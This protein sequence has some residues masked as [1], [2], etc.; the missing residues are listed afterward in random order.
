M[1]KLRIRSLGGRKLIVLDF[2]ED[3]IKG[4]VQLEIRSAQAQNARFSGGFYEGSVLKIL[5]RNCPRDS[6]KEVVHLELRS[7]RAQNA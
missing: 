4:M 7:S 3:S 5:M 1:R 2:L 6:V